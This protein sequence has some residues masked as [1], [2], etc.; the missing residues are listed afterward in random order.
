KPEKAA[1]KPVEE[2]YGFTPEAE[3][4]ALS[5]PEPAPEPANPEKKGFGSKLKRLFRRK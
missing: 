3:P 5:E 4:V 1:V 2:D